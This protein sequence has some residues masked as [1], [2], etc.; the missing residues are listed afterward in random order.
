MKDQPVVIQKCTPV[1][2]MVAT[3]IIPEK[4]L[5]PDTL[6]ALD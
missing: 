5:L 4:V 1:G 3:N 6:E 2:R